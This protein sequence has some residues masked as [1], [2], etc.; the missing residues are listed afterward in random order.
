MLLYNIIP[1][2]QAFNTIYYI[3]AIASK[4]KIYLDVCL[5]DT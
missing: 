1:T 5:M 4:F 3:H 2:H